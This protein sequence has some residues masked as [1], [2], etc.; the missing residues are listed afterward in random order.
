[1]T[2]PNERPIFD[3]RPASDGPPSALCSLTASGAAVFTDARCPSCRRIV[4]LVPGVVL[5]EVRALVGVRQASGRGPVA[6]C[7]RCGGYCE[8]VTHR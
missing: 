3:V 6:S 1:M 4:L 7:R 8:V 5:V 2:V